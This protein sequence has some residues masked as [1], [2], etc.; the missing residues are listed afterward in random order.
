[1]REDLR[2]G[3]DRIHDVAFYVL[4]IGIES[5]ASTSQDNKEEKG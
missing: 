4:S 2:N 1:M 5:H 3:L